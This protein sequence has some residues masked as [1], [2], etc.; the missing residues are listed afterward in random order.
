MALRLGSPP[1]LARLRLQWHAAR[2]QFLRQS[3]AWSEQWGVLR[4]DTRFWG[5]R[6]SVSL[7][8]HWSLRERARIRQVARQQAQLVAFTDKYEDLVDLL[9][10]AAKEGANEEQSR[11]YAEL[12]VWMQSHYGPMRPRVRG[13]LNTPDNVFDPF[14]RLFGPQNLDEVINDLSAIENVMTTRSA[15]DAY[16]ETLR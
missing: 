8:A 15:L 6:L 13:F 4:A 3:R 10:W 12:R 7:V 14:E 2:N 5:Q 11:K 9:C 1:G 16:S